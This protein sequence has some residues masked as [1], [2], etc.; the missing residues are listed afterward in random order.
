MGKTDVNYISNL[1]IRMFKSMKRETADKEQRRNADTPESSHN[2]G[3]Y[4]SLLRAKELSKSK[5]GHLGVPLAVE[6]YVAGFYISV[7]NLWF[8]A[9]VKVGKPARS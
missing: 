2:T 6:Q 9:L 8:K 7:H 1:H 5:V 3:C 4:M